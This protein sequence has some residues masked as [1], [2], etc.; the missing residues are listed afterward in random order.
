MNDP[1]KKMVLIFFFFNMRSSNK[2]TKTMSAARQMTLLRKTGVTVETV[3]QVTSVRLYL[4]E[5]KKMRVNVSTETKQTPK[6]GSLTDILW[7]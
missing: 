6:Q 2:Q 3:Q 7:G 1:L 4:S 5:Q